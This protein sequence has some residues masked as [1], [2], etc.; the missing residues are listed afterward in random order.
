MSGRVQLIEERLTRRLQPSEL[1]IKDQSHL[2][3]GHEGARDGRG[4]FDIVIVSE[5]FA[6]VNL[7]Q[8]HMMVYDALGDLMKSDI[9][10]VRIRALTQSEQ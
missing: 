4:H 3:A 10:A 6:D 5:L 2:H 8:R 9:H 1:R 7:L